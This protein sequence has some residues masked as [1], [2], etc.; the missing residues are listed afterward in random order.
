MVGSVCTSCAM[1]KL[2]HNKNKKNRKMN[3]K[4]T[5]HALST[6]SSDQRR[7]KKKKKTKSASLFISR[8]RPSNTNANKIRVMRLTRW[9]GKCRVRTQHALKWTGHC[10]Y[11]ILCIC[12]RCRNQTKFALNAFFFFCSLSLCIIRSREEND[13][14]Q[15][16]EEVEVES[17]NKYYN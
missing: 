7:I 4:M 8:S 11:C 10:A 1:F 5:I 12:I 13:G 6:H 9:H 3:F 15:S 2:R 16:E 17:W 14:K